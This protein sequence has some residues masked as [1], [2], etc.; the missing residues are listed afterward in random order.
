[1]GGFKKNL[2]QFYIDGFPQ[3]SKI[4]YKI[5]ATYKSMVESYISMDGAVFVL[6]INMYYYKMDLVS[7][8]HIAR[9]TEMIGH[10][11]CGVLCIYSWEKVPD[12]LPVPCPMQ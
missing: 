3:I 1:M 10:L 11:C 8:G 4:S 12:E 5:Q 6:F 7:T 9:A 2:M